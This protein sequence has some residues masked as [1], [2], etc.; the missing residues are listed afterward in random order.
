M[1]TLLHLDSSPSTSSISRELTRE[2]VQTS[3]AAQPH[4]HV[5]YRDLA[6]NPPQPI[7]AHWIGAAYTPPSAR[8]AEQTRTLALS[9][10]LLRELAQAEEYVLGVGMHIFSVPYVP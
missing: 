3:K 5:I 6:A 10:E 7:D 9:D 2:V 8:S 1:P 4:G